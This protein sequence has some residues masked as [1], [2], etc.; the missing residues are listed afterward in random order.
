MTMIPT[1]CY[2]QFKVSPNGMVA[3]DDSD[4]AVFNIE[5]KTAKELYTSVESFFMETFRS[6]DHVLSKQQYSMIQMKGMF[7]NAIPFKMFGMQSAYH[8]ELILHIYFKDGKIRVNN[9]IIRVLNSDYTEGVVFQGGM[10]KM[11]GQRS[12]YNKKG[13]LKE[14]D[15]AR[16]LEE[17]ING[18]VNKMII[19]T[20]DEENNDW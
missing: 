5:G 11:L 1:L 7:D 3:E 8:L 15:I 16:S 17:A 18:F 12:I 10:G 20:K 13:K 19:F 14:E 2:S 4:Y 6:P 9:P